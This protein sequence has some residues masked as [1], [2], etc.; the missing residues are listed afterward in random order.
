MLHTFCSLHVP[1]DAY[2]KGI[3]NTTNI[4]SN[5]QVLH[6]G[7]TTPTL[8]FGLVALFRAETNSN[9]AHEMPSSTEIFSKRRKIY[10]L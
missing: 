10:S 8:F 5:T 1:V 6:T 7:L 4:L 9:E 2:C 3:F